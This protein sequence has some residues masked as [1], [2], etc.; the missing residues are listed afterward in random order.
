MCRSE[1]SDTVGG[2]MTRRAWHRRETESPWATRCPGS[3]SS[4]RQC[5]A[6]RLRTY[7]GALGGPRPRQGHAV[8]SPASGPSAMAPQACAKR[9]S[10]PCPRPLDSLRRCSANGSARPRRMF[11]GASLTA[12]ARPGCWRMGSLQSCKRPSRLHRRGRLQLYMG[13][14]RPASRLGWPR[15]DEE[16]LLSPGRTK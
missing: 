7:S 14:T 12:A 1:A 15:A 8:V 10:A 6:Q 11:V 4:R 3:L 9:V 13:C 5:K 16:R 2:S